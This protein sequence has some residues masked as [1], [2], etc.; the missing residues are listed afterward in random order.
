MHL[1]IQWSLQALFVTTGEK[2]DFK[3]EK[4]GVRKLKQGL[5]APAVNCQR[6]AQFK[7]KAS[8]GEADAGGDSK[9]SWQI[10][11]LPSP[12]VVTRRAH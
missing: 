4:G 6:Q 8:L 2:E 5:G 3:R 11:L 7:V 12:I 10:N 1:P 9:E